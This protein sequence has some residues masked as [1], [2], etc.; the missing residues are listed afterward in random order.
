MGHWGQSIILPANID[1]NWEEDYKAKYAGSTFDW[2]L[3][4]IYFTNSF[5]ENMQIFNNRLHTDLC[6]RFTDAD[7]TF[8]RYTNGCA[9]RYGEADLS[10]GQENWN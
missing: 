1:E 9:H 8:Y 3:Q 6:V 2:H 5:A 4:K 10:Q 7:K